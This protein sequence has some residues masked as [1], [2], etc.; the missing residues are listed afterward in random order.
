MRISFQPKLMDEAL[1]LSKSGDV[2]TVN[3]AS[4]D[5]TGLGDGATIPAGVVPCDWIVGPIERVSG[6]L[7]MRLFLPVNVFSSEA[8]RF[9]ADIVNPTDGPISLP[10]D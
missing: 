4:F 7:Q 9:P 5:F 2:L 3:G 8:R 10:E 6:V 1:V